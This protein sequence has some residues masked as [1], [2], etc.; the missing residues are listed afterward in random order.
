MDK[1]KRVF[2]LKNQI[3]RVLLKSIKLNKNLSY[4]RRYQAHYYLSN[5]P[6]ISNITKLTNR[7][8]FSGRS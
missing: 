3:K 8:S 2:F 7:C 1:L 6:K 4:L 5:L